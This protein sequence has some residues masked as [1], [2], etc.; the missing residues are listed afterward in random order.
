MP[1]LI[2]PF[3]IAFGK[4]PMQLIERPVEFTE[5]CEDFDNPNPE[6]NAYV[7]TGVRGCGK[8]ILLASIRNYYKE[9]SD[10]IV[11]DLVPY[12]DILEL[13]A[14]TLYQEGKFKKL[15]L[16]G[17]FSFSFHGASFS[18][19]GDKPVTNVIT[20]LSL[21]LE[22]AQKKNKKVLITIDEVSGSN[23]TKS[24]F[25]A[26]QLFL[27]KGY[28]V[29]LLM[30]GISKNVN[31]IEGE[32]T[33]TFLLCAPKIRLSK[34][35]MARIA[36]VYR[37][38]LGVDEGG[39]IKLAKFTKSYAFAFQL[40]GSLLFKAGKKAVDAS[41][42]REFDALIRDR[43][44]ATIFKELTE[45]ERRIVFCAIQPGKETN[46]AIMAEL[47]MK[48]GTLSTYKTRLSNAGVIEPEAHGKVKFA[49]P[50]FEDY[51]RYLSQ[52]EGED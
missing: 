40:L 38:C 30:T 27:S 5:I 10:W 36:E 18:I 6:S 39:S 46:G 33:L 48:K 26:F 24:F 21:M 19:P 28:P 15:F 20:M 43:A 45:Q 47:G 3:N 31:S 52:F 13:F 50:R 12:K 44:Y 37:N 16:K 4:E 23:E 7:I 1:N 29:F 11:V 17:E 25:H 42:L 49:L 2:N 14:A 51:L 34:L 8:T 41:I 32:K 35:D 9:K 22:H